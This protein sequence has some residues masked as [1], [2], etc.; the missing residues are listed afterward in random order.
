MWGAEGEAGYMRLHGSAINPYSNGDT[1]DTTAIG[2]WFGAITGRAGWATDRALFYA[3]GGVGFTDVKSTVID[4]C[5]AAP[6]GTSLLNATSRNSTR[7]FYVGGG[8]IEWAWTGNWTLKAEYLFLGLNETL[9]RLRSPVAE[10]PLDR[11]SARTTRS[12]ASTPASSA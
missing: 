6:C 11:R 4:T 1:L 2:D 9:R 5:N 12:T 8:G 7:A 10:Q 3:K